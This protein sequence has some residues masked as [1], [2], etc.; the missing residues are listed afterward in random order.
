MFAIIWSYVVE[1]DWQAE[2]EQAYGPAGD[3]ADFFRK[4]HGYIRTELLHDTKMENRYTTIDYWETEQDYKIF[5]DQFTAEYQ[6]LDAR[7][8]AWTIN[9]TLIGRF[10]IRSEL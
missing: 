5:H 7:F 6:A 1:P 9:E 2:F 3:W 4:G 10:E 8:E